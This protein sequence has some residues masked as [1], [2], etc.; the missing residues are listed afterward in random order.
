MEGIQADVQVEP[1]T[2]QKMGDIFPVDIPIEMIAHTDIDGKI[3]PLRL[4]YEK[5]GGEK[6]TICFCK[7]D[8]IARG[9]YNFVGIKELQFICST[10]AD[11][12]RISMEIRYRVANEKWRIH[13]FL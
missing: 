13:R 8:T 11:G 1:K 9:E 10:V 5:E 7:E 2:I 3:T 6:V 4:R 12:T